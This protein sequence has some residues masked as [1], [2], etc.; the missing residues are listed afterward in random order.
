[1]PQALEDLCC[2]EAECERLLSSKYRTPR[3]PLDV[4]PE[5]GDAASATPVNEAADAQA[6]EGTVELPAEPTDGAAETEGSHM[7]QAYRN[8][9]ER[10][11]C[12]ECLSKYTQPPLLLAILW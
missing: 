6:T 5:A 1:M 3:K 10:A 4:V 11:C 7:V 8:A 9:G 2:T 12:T